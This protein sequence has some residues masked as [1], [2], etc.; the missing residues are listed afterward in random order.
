VQKL[1]EHMAAMTLF[2]LGCRQLSGFLKGSPI[3]V[4]SAICARPR[5]APQSPAEPEG[6]FTQRARV[7][8]RVCYF[9]TSVSTS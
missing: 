1:A 7:L 2:G 5:S 4:P 8:P 6:G 3:P 9:S